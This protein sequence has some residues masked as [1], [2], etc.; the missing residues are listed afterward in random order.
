MKLVERKTQG[1]MKTLA[2]ITLAL[3]AVTCAYEVDDIPEYMRERLD[4]YV[5]LKKNWERKWL[6]MTE[7]ERNFYEKQ[8][9]AR[10]EH[11][12]ESVKQRIHQRISEM[13]VEDRIKLREYLY[14]RFPEL[15]ATV[16]SSNEADEIKAIID[17]LPEMI[18]EKISDFISIRY[19]PAAAYQNIDDTDFIDF[20][21]IPEIVE[22]TPPEE[23]E[24]VPY[25]EYELPEEVRT[26]LD[27]FLLKRED[28]KRRWENLPAEKREA[29]E[30]YIEGKLHRK[31]E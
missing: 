29:F 17:Q 13:P 2:I 27:A 28:W 25:S 4:K 15:E 8:I 7:D 12:P 10:L 16:A 14:K 22:L 11:I 19:A 23:G 3:I 26:R 6:L 20:P 21:D 18:R 9:Y 30:K 31:N 24:A 1:T 5:E